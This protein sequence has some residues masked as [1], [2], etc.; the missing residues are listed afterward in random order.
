MPMR[1]VVTGIGI[2]SPLAIGANETMDRLLAG[3]RA[4][5]RVTLFDA[6]AQRTALAAE[7]RGLSVEALAPAEQGAQWSRTDAMAVLAAREALAEAKL[8]PREHAIDLA[9]GGTTGGM[10]ETEDL[11]AEMV[12]DPS[13]Q[14]P[15]ARMLSHPLSATADRLRAA[16]GPFGR[17]RTLCSACSSGANALLLAASWI[18]AGRATMALAGGADGLCRL[19]YTGFNALAAVDPEPCKPFDRRRAGLNLGEGAA[20]LVL[21][22]EDVARARG[23]RPIVELAGFAVGAEAH[24]ITN[25]EPSGRTAAR[26]VAQAIASAGLSARDIDYV[27]A[28]GTATPL[29]DAME[30]AALRAA[31]GD[32]VRRIAVSSSKGQLGHT[33]GAAGAIEAAITALAIA[34]QAAPPTAGLEE[35]DPACELSHVAGVARPMRIRAALSSSFGF[36]G[37]DTVLVLAEPGAAPATERARRP[38]VVTGAATV[39]PLGVLGAIAS[40]AYV[41]ADAP[42]AAPGAIAFDAAAH[43]DAERARRFDRAARLVTTAVARA[44][45]DAGGLEAQPERGTVGAI[46]GTA[47]GSIDASAAFMTRA[48]E[49]GA[50]LASPAAFPNLVP[51]SPV[52]HAS[53]YLGLR[54]PV[55]AV[56]DLATTAEAAFATAVELLESGEADAMA[57]GSVEEASRIV[58]RVLGPLFAGPSAAERTRTEG[59]SA[60]VLEREENA[61]SRGAKRLARVVEVRSGRGELANGITPPSRGRPLLVLA[62]DEPAASEALRGVGWDRVVR[63]SVERATGEH[64]GIGGFALVAA[65]GAIAS[66]RAD[67]ALVFGRSADRWI[68][69]LL[70]TA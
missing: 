13:R 57:C 24:H 6:S 46:V 39:G 16:I 10:F 28:H 45:D 19:T 70:A 12:R 64:E 9:V 25:P 56:A 30:A 48:Y 17:T 41:A 37:T 35:P 15:M 55:L 2:V 66:G 43:L 31:L 1:V 7:V 68:A 26:L 8:D 59:A 4:Q 36:G 38:V 34:R 33:L 20:F 52:G 29:N 58:E 21:E 63:H 50:R 53:V 22:R 54:G 65:V 47:F 14:E 67:E 60:I 23:A 62:H 18:R 40:T 61:A 11:L 49:K 5:R 69:I 44:F 51:S 3:E 32:E 42:A 27:N